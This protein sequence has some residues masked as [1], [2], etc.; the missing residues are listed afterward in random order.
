[1]EFLLRRRAYFE[2]QEAAAHYE[3]EREGLGAEFLRCIE[4]AFASIERN[5]LARPLYYGNARRAYLRRFPYSIY[6]IAAAEWVSVVAVFHG[7]RDPR[8]PGSVRPTRRG[9]HVTD[10]TILEDIA[11]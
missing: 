8:S 5:P 3:I 7:R 9:R 11:L 6:Y 10:A 2:I 4:A 1:M